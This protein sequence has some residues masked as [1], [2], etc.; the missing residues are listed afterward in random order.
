MKNEYALVTGA[1]KR[2]G[3]FICKFLALQGYHVII[4]YN[5]SK[6]EAER[7]L[8]DII[9]SN[10]KANLIKADLSS[11]IQVRNLIPKINKKYGQLSML[12]NNASIF[13]KDD[14]KSISSELWDKH[15]DVNLKAPLFLSKDFANQ[16]SKR[17]G[18]III[19][20]LDQSVLTYRPN[21]I[22]YSVSKNSLWYLTR[23]LAQALSPSIRVCAIGPGPTLQ[24]K[25]QTKKDFETQ[26]KVT[27]LGIGPD[28][29]EINNAI[30]FII[31][32]NSFTGQMIVLD[33]GEPVSYTHLTLP[34][35][36]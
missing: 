7:T 27:P 11:A 18:G 12:I 23:S 21:F 25:R 24:G 32:N 28:L 33:G 17:K 6:L 4:H 5:N 30:N 26:K 34:T 20:F 35:K 22:S 36:A 31:K 3:S 10:G 29:E 9:K 13:E 14:I 19:N 8:K 1:G 2:V 15:I 16:F